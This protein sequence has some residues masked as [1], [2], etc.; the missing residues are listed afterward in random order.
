MIARLHR[1]RRAEGEQGFV[2]V[3]V[4]MVA[5]II[6]LLVTFLTVGAEGNVRPAKKSANEQSALAAAE[7][8]IQAYYASLLAASGCTSLPVLATNAGA[9][10]GLGPGSGAHTAQLVSADTAN[11]FTTQNQASYSYQVVAVT[12]SFVRVKSTGTVGTSPSQPFSTSKTLIAD[13]SGA[14]Y[15]KYAYYSTYET[16]PSS[17]VQSEFGPRTIAFDDASTLSA[18][19]A[20]TGLTKVVWGGVPTTGAT[21]SQWCDALYYTPA[22]GASTVNASTS[23]A[24]RFSRASGLPL[25]YDFQ[26]PLVSATGGSVPDPTHNGVCQ[27]DFTSGT[28]INGQMYSRD[29]YLLSAGTANGTG[30]SFTV[31]PQSA[32]STSDSPAGGQ[33]WNPFPYIGAGSNAVNRPVSAGFTLALPASGAAALTSNTAT[34]V[35]EYYGPTR[36][37]VK[38]AYAYVTSPLTA[39]NAG[40]ACTTSGDSGVSAPNVPAGLAGAGSPSVVEAKIPVANTLVYVHKSPLTSSTAW[41]PGT[42]IFQLKSTTGA[43]ATLPNPTVTTTTS[44]PDNNVASNGSLITSLLGGLVQLPAPKADGAW[45]LDWTYD[46]SLTATCDGTLLGSGNGNLNQYNFETDLGKTYTQFKAQVQAA[47]YHLTDTVS[48]TRASLLTD[49]QTAL[50]GVFNADGIGT[51]GSFTSSKTFALTQ[52][53]LPTPPTNS[54]GTAKSYTG[55]YATFAPT[56]DPGYATTSGCTT[57]TA[58]GASTNTS[59]TAP[60]QADGDPLLGQPAYGTSQGR[61]DCTQDAIKVTVSRVLSKSSCSGTVILGSCS[62]TWSYAWDTANAKPQFDF[63][64]TRQQTTANTIVASAATA[65][66]P[67][68]ADVTK[69]QTNTDGPGDVYV[70]GDV[71][72]KLSIVAEHDIVITGNLTYDTPGTDVT[73]LIANDSVRVYHPVRCTDTATTVTTAGFCPNDTTGLSPKGVLEFTSSNFAKHPS[74]QYTNL[75]RTATYAG[76][77]D[78][79]DLATVSVQAGIF[80]LGGAFY[81][82]NY[83]RGAGYDPDG[84]LAAGGLRSVTVTGGVYQLH[85]GPLGVQWEIKSDATTRPTSGYTLNI[86]W[87]STMG[88]R[89]LPYLPQLSGVNSNGTWQVISTSAVS[90]S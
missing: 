44:T 45:N 79:T 26:E 12:S 68:S 6:S 57:G 89:G 66:F 3:Y 39:A 27:V 53:S 18:A 32:W 31:A 37:F 55:Y 34:L 42:P 2:L 70:E 86:T 77:Q 5:T 54:G 84:T 38:G 52:A 49:M 29:A 8:G 30:P 85:H 19:G 25:G 59:L 43:G 82:D 40:S 13:I 81:A 35:C 7:A 48:G 71:T 23:G 64:S 50:N 76:A 56:S 33:V 90:G 22:T 15:T 74:R 61:T 60:T 10:A 1:V 36:V 88:T 16:I 4:L 58:S 20:D 78:G 69:Y 67:L 46:C 63:T 87:D 51:G 62:G 73:D 75:S 24:G 9:C 21:G 17:L 65:S 72:G 80:A 14:D 41:T 28:T 47:A 83:D 11:A